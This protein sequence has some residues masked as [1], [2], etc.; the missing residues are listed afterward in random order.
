MAKKITIKYSKV[1]AP[2]AQPVAPICRIFEPNN[3]AADL[4]AFD[5][6]Y[7]DTNVEGW[8]EG[9]AI[10]A[11]MAGMVAHPGLVAAIRKAMNDG[12][13]VM[14]EATEAEALYAGEY[15]KALA[16]QG[17]EVKIEEAAAASTPGK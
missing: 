12:K 11:F 17:I 8:G 9:T 2:S 16:D 4:K 1:S 3:A 6:T 14:N 10:D 7:Y 15:A 13:Y 5:G